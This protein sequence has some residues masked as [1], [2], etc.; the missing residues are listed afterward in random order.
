[1]DL[2]QGQMKIR[3]L[4]ELKI[5]KPD[6]KNTL[7]IKRA[8][9]PQIKSDDYP[10]FIEYLKQNGAILKNQKN[11]SADILKPIQSEFSDAGI[12]KQMQK[13]GVRKK[14]IVSSDNYIID[15]H[16]RWLVAVNTGDTVDVLR[17]TNINVRDLLK[18]VLDFP[19]TYF[20]DIYTEDS[21]WGLMKRKI[22]HHI[23]RSSD[24]KKMA[25]I[26]HDIL[27]RKYKET[28][29]QLRHALGYYASMLARQH[30][31]L[32]W[33][34]LEQE[35]LDTFGNGMFESIFDEPIEFTQT[36]E[37]D[38]NANSMPDVYLDMD[39]VLADFFG[40]W[41]K[42]AGVTSGNWK[43]IPPANIDPT[44]DKMIG[45]DFFDRLP[46]FPTTDSLV[47]IVKNVF[48]SFKIL[49]SPLRGDHQNSKVQ[50]IKWIKREL[51]QQPEDIIIASNKDR[52]AVKPD[53]T[54]NILIDDRGK[55]IE[56]WR[57]RG[58]FGIKYQADEDSIEKVIKALEEYKTKYI[59][60]D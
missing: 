52:Y 29:G 3:D 45:T 7:G 5:E 17:I 60:K 14:V 34:E 24:Y 19:K 15:G 38:L 58:G 4:T 49:S 35:Y 33:R 23:T 55:N 8:D 46:K 57:S 42:M 47:N 31:K 13:K 10:E 28:G 18:L 48:G 37:D 36:N 11:V 30:G 20:K 39:G 16:H 21:P 59:D 43:D 12:E 40:E 22:G 56:G 54:P 9:M 50:K 2:G 6:S 25:E 27:T 41:A 53:G 26:L 51:K 44:L 1:M 32:D